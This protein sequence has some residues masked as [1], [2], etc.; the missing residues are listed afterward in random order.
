MKIVSIKKISKPSMRYDIEVAKNENFFANNVLVHNCSITAYVNNG[1]IGVC[2][3]NLDLQETEGNTYWSVARKEKL[4]EKLQSTGRNLAIQGEL[5]G[6]GIQ[7][8]RYNIKGHKFFLFDVFDIDKQEYF[9]PEERR[10]F[11]ASLDITHVPVYDTDH[12]MTWDMA[13]IL[14]DA[15]SKSCLNDKAEQEGVVYKCNDIQ[16][17]FKAISNLFLLKVGD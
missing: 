10:K 3:R 1:E 11:A 12:V 5:I 6:E 2:S 15:E 8:N 16:F 13:V 7:K 14:G 4:I 17:S 9:T